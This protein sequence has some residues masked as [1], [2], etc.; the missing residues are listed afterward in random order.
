MSLAEGYNYARYL[1]E[2]ARAKRIE[3]DRDHLQARLISEHRMADLF[4]RQ[5]DKLK[6]DYLKAEE[7]VDM[8]MRVCSKIRYAFN[9]NKDDGD[10]DDAIID[11]NFQQEAI[12]DMVAMI[13]S[14]AKN[15][16]AVVIKII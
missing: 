14:I 7:E 15:H 3:I 12:K 5:R 1:C 4:C 13:D 8:L 9:R 11:L 2:K 6:V 16:S 10:A